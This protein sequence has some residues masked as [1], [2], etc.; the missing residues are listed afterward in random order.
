VNL[1]IE[2]A[3]DAALSK[4]KVASAVSLPSPKRM[5]LRSPQRR[6]L[7]LLPLLQ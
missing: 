3:V 2:R 7:L 1:Q 6:S 5:K 4:E